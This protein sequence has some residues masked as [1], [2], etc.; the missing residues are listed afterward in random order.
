MRIAIMVRTSS[1]RLILAVCVFLISGGAQGASPVVFEQNPDL[2]IPSVNVEPVLQL[3]VTLSD[4]IPVGLTDRGE[5]AI[6]PITGGSFFGDGIRGEVMPG[7]ADW[8]LIRADGVQEIVARYTIRTD[9]GQIIFVDN[10][11]ISHTDEE[12]VRYR[13]TA[14]KFHAPQG[15]YDW[16]NKNIFVGTITSV[17]EPRAVIIR[18]YRVDAAQ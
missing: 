18:I 7:G 11:G 13:M 10:Q 4:N 12:G 15:P 3:H 14:P 2:T 16:L 6:V 9:D 5:R 17:T 8:Q 1:L